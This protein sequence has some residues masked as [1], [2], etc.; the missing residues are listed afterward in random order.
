[1]SRNTKNISSKK[2]YCKVCHDAG[3]P[4]SEYTSHWVK[5]LTGN[6]TCPT[7]LNTECR[8]CFKL[9]H[10]A[11]FCDNLIKGNKEKERIERSAQVVAEK[12]VALQNKKPVGRFAA[13]CDDNEPE[14][15]VSANIIVNEYPSLCVR[16]KKVEVS[17]LEVKTGWA[18]IAAKPKEVQSF[19]APVRNS[20][21]LVLSDYIKN[22]PAEKLVIDVNVAPWVS[23]PIITKSWVDWSEGE[24]E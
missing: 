15:K 21:F 16:V 23:K 5:D 17:K 13:L 4:E 12:P 19:D 2:A 11:K 18:A 1:M 7:L 3:K 9:G 10:T 20:G 22:A 8:Y 14:K 24:D 6:T